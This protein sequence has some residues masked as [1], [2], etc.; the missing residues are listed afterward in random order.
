MF[1]YVAYQQE[2]RPLGVFN[3]IIHIFDT[4]VAAIQS[5]DVAQI[6]DLIARTECL[7]ITLDEFKT[8]AAESLQIR[9]IN[10]CIAHKISER[11]TIADEISLQRRAMDDPKRMVYEQYVA[12]CVLYGKGLKA[13]MGYVS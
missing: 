5:D 1:K 13:K 11:Y 3:G 7:E 4:K 9:Y 12:E 8:A 6:D 2:F 10:E